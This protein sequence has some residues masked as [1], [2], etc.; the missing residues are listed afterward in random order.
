MARNVHEI[1][2]K[3]NLPITRDRQSV[4]ECL[5]NY[6]KVFLTELKES[7]SLATNT[8]FPNSFYEKLEKT[9]FPQIKEQCKII[10][11]ITNLNP[12]YLRAQQYELFDKLMQLLIENDA[13]RFLTLKKGDIM[14]RTRSESSPFERPFERKDLF[15]IPYD[16]REITS[17]QRFSDLGDSCLYL[18]IFPSLRYF[19]DD[20]IDLS[21]KESG[22]PKIFYFSIF[23]VQDNLNCLHFAKQ[24]STYLKEY[25]E[26]NT[27]EE[28]NDRQEAIEQYLMT[29]PLRTAISMSVKDKFIEHGINYHEEYNFPQL[30]IQWLQ[31]NSTFDGLTYQSATKLPETKNS[32]S[33][34][35][36]FPVKNIN[37]TTGYDEKLKKIFKL[38]PPKKID[39]FARIKTLDNNIKDVQQYARELELKLTKYQ[40]TEVHPYYNLLAICYSFDSICSSIKN[41]N[42]THMETSFQQSNTLWRMAMLIFKT[43]ENA[44]T[45]EQWVDL[46]KR[47]TGDTVLTEND[48]QDVLLRFNIVVNALI[49]LKNILSI[50]EMNAYLFSQPDYQFVD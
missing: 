29:F 2:Y 49:E 6:Y 11:D 38:S 46:Y 45:A 30:L 22:M 43:I 20:M 34:N 4:H 41:V 47:Y 39:F 48:Y 42:E 19:A 32:K 21:W 14:V 25:D 23:E 40:G 13:F 10:L 15:H 12:G 1:I 27:Q 16:K 18:S 35:I 36:V 24:G 9:L 33:Y 50:N 7:F 3:Y 44:K 5:N 26:A 28:R 37:R 8:D 31:K 17:H